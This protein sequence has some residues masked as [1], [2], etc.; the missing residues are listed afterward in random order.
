[1]S[2]GGTGTLWSSASGRLRR[3]VFIENA[4]LEGNVK[5]MEDERAGVKVV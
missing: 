3:R 4:S 2:F 1:M 5:K